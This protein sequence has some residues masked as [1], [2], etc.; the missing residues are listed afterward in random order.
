MSAVRTAHSPLLFSV[1]IPSSP[2]PTFETVCAEVRAIVG[3]KVLVGHTLFNDLAAIEHKH[4]YEDMRDTALFYPL[5]RLAGVTNEG[6]YPALRKL[7]KEVLGHEIQKGEHS[8]VGR[9]S[10][11]VKVRSSADSGAQIEDARSTMEVFLTVRAEYEAG[12][13]NGDDVI[14]CLPTCVQVIDWSRECADDHH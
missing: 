8:P 13:A 4:Q 3:H 11:G 12:L 10:G 9:E 2:A 14:A 6:Q 7:A 1:L 5:R